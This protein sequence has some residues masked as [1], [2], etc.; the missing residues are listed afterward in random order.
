MR[1]LWSSPDFM[2]CSA[3]QVTSLS[4]MLPCGPE[5][6]ANSPQVCAGEWH[7]FPSLL[8]LFHLKYQS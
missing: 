6:E 5:K 1:A 4:W 2:P 3:F 8:Y 7:H